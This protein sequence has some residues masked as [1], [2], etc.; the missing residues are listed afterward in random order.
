MIEY[1]QNSLHAKHEIFMERSINECK[2][3]QRMCVHI[4]I[5]KHTLKI[6]MKYTILKSLPPTKENCTPKKNHLK[7]FHKMNA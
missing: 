4:H 6:T 2:L 5:Y 1:I 3:Q 7:T